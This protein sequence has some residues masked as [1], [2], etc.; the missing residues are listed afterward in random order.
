MKSCENS[1]YSGFTLIECV[2]AMVIAL[3]GLM[4]VYSLVVF[5][6]RTQSISQELATANSLARSKIE[7]LRNAAPR[8]NGGSLTSNIEGFYD[9]PPGGEYLRR[10]QISGDLAGTQIVIV[11]VVPRRAQSMPLPEVKV[12]TRMR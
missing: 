1:K 3:V 5:S 6:V 11:T 8:A 7:E 12:T 10:W 9:A 4:A 2:I